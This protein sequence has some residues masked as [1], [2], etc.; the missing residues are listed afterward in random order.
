MKNTCIELCFCLIFF[1]SLTSVILDDN[2]SN[3]SISDCVKDGTSYRVFLVS[4]CLNY[5]PFMYLIMCIRLKN[6]IAR[7]IHQLCGFTAGMCMV[8]VALVTNRDEAHLPIAITLFVSAY[9]HSV[10][11]LFLEPN[12]TR[13]F[14]VLAA[15]FIIVGIFIS[16]AHKGVWISDFEWL[17]ICTFSLY[18][19]T[20]WERK[21]P[22]VPELEIPLM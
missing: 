14:V 10:M 7:L 12:K 19:T 1:G 3:T 8:L 20:F 6:P 4:M 17:F 13:Q 5:L 9:L 2:E 11:S 22:M 16:F 21:K 18:L 15:T